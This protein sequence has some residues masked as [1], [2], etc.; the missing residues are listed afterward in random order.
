MIDCILREGKEVSGYSAHLSSGLKFTTVRE[1]ND[2]AA[3]SYTRQAVRRPSLDIVHLRSGGLTRDRTV[4][5]ERMRASSNFSRRRLSS[6]DEEGQA[7]DRPQSLSKQLLA[8]FEDAS[9][10][11]TSLA[12]KMAQHNGLRQFAVDFKNRAPPLELRMLL[13]E[14]EVAIE[15]NLEQLR[16][17]ATSLEGLE[18]T[19]TG[20]NEQVCTAFVQ[21]LTN[22]ADQFHEDFGQQQ[23][24][25]QSIAAASP[26]FAP[27]LTP[28]LS[29]RLAAAMGSPASSPSASPK[30]KEI[31]P[32]AEASCGS[33]LH[34][35]LCE[36]TLQEAASSQRVPFAGVMSLQT[37]RSASQHVF[38]P[39][40]DSSSEVFDM[41]LVIDPGSPVRY[42]CAAK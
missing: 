2:D 41:E 30:L 40:P 36:N 35:G 31:C 10:V 17:I 28:A 22:L 20:R 39:P 29:K 5:F 26:L 25:L 8:I 12:A 37:E 18:Q 15:Q 16:E 14:L 6:H 33:Q 32:A 7:D 4:H 42:S 13:P 1:E 34:R 38:Q 23:K 11:H 19:A 9:S 3:W 21:H 27:I 24:Q